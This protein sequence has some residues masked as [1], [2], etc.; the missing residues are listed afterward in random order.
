MTGTEGGTSL[1]FPKAEVDAVDGGYALNGHKI[2]G[3]LSPCATLFFVPARLADSEGGY[4]SVMCMLGRGT[5]GQEI[6]DNWDALACARP[7]AVTSYTATCDCP[8]R[9]TSSGRA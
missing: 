8:R 9:A 3:T 6:R 5:P 4:E 1:R 2:F 7:A